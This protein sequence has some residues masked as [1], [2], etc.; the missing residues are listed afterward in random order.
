MRNLRPTRPSHGHARPLAR[1]LGITALVLA[2][3]A[4]LPAA[5]AQLYRYV[6]EN[7]VTV[8]SQTPPPG[9]EAAAITVDAAAP[10][11]ADAAAA[12]EQL[13][14]EIERDFD[15]RNEAARAAEEAAEQAAA[16]KAR[17]ENC[18]AARTNLAT[19]TDLGARVLQMPDGSVTR[20]SD[21]EREALM[22]KAEMEIEDL[23]D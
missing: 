3:P 9:G 16:A 10:S 5:A 19:L 7:G 4:A 13:R 1:L 23:C 6:D 11:A 20:I 14:E 15:A 22:R 2:A 12:R 21:E 18:E 8:Y 17:A